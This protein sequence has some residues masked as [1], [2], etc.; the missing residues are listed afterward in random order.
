[1]REIDRETWGSNLLACRRR[2]WSSARDDTIALW[3]LGGEP[4]PLT[5]LSGCKIGRLPA[6]SRRIGFDA[7]SVIHL[8]AKR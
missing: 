7:E 8:R 1:M 5:S 4:P 2:R 6:A 3:Q